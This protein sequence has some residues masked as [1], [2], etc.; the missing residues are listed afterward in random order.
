[1]APHDMEKEMKQ[2]NGGPAFPVHDPHSMAPDSVAEMMRLASGMILRDYFAAKALP[3]VA[4]RFD[5][6]YGEDPAEHAISPMSFGSIAIDAYE[7]AD[8]MLAART[9]WPHT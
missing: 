7:L 8:A 2:D 6:Q 3:I 1:M 4:A 9:A 5:I